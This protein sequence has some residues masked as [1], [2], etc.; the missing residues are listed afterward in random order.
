MKLNP[1]YAFFISNI[2]VKTYFRFSAFFGII[3]FF[4][5]LIS[6]RFLWTSIYA[7]SDASTHVLSFQDL[8]TYVTLAAILGLIVDINPSGE[9]SQSILSGNI[10]MELSR[11]IDYRLY[12]FSKSMSDLFFKLV[13]TIFPVILFLVFFKFLQPTTL[14]NVVFFI[15]SSFFGSIL[16]FL[17]NFIVGL[18]GF[19]TT[20]VWGIDMIKTALISF[21]AGSI[22]PLN[23]FPE[24]LRLVIKWLP[25]RGLYDIPINF[26][27]SSK[28]SYS[29]LA[30]QMLW[31]LVLIL[32]VNS[33]LNI[34]QKKLFIAGG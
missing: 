22:I 19:V 12:I 21:T 23:F 5:Y 3:R 25:F 2:K 20:R 30:F 28:I 8:L 26:Y 31:I 33:L 32:I 27:I 11:P 4:I 1:Y 17:I 24:K 15:I 9:I 34:F 10:G 13:T 6:L 7:S 14:L 16:I 29:L 18:M